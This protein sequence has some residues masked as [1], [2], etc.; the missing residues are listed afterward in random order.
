[1][2]G[3]AIRYVGDEGRLGWATND[4]W[5]VGTDTTCCRVTLPL[6]LCTSATVLVVANGSRESAFI[7]KATDLAFRLTRL[8]C[9]S[10]YRRFLR[11][12][13]GGRRNGRSDGKDWTRDRLT[14]PY[15]VIAK[16]ARCR[17]SSN[18]LAYSTPNDARLGLPLG[19]R[20]PVDRSLLANLW[21]LPLKL[22]AQ[23]AELC[24]LIDE[25]ICA[26][27]SVSS[28]EGSK[29]QKGNVFEAHHD[30]C[31]KFQPYL[32]NAG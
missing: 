15:C 8:M 1:M 17:T 20:R 11:T 21:R 24:A 5:G 29:E 4:E 14:L 27:L 2:L 16:T 10:H 22:P 19:A 31:D 13:R 30:D 18:V 26:F 9:A 23:F 32:P 28:A 7:F 25:V 3:V 12:K 6:S